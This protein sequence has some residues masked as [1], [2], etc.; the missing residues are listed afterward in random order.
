MI[1]TFSKTSEAIQ[2]IKKMMTNLSHKLRVS[3]A[4]KNKKNAMSPNPENHKC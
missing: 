1:K 2:P 4:N 3:S